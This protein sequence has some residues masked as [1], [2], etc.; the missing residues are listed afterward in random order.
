MVLERG[1][2]SL[3]GAYKLSPI[4]LLLFNQA[5]MKCTRPRRKVIP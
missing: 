5:V 3:S 1:D 2:F 4:T